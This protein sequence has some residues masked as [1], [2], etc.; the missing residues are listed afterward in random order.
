MHGGSP[1]RCGAIPPRVTENRSAKI[2]CSPKAACAEK[3][4]ILAAEQCLANPQSLR[5]IL[6]RGPLAALRG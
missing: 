2:R 5:K 3:A 4:R 6:L 1:N